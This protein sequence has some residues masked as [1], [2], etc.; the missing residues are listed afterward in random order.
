MNSKQPSRYIKR[1]MGN[2]LKMQILQRGGIDLD[3]S[4]AKPKPVVVSC[5]R[6]NIVNSMETK[7]CSKCS[8]P[9]VPEAYDEVKAAERKDIE[10]LRQEYAN[11]SSTLHTVVTIMVTADEVTKKKLAQQLIE[12]GGYIPKQELLKQKS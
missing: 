8:Y 1:R 11:V 4:I 6:C 7:F 12:K 10:E 5:P 2:D 3:D 9:L